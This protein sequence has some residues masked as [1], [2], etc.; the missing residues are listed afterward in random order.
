ML[1]SFSVHFLAIEDLYRFS[2]K[3]VCA[4]RV[5]CKQRNK[6][7]DFLIVVDNNKEN[8]LNSPQ[9]KTKWNSRGI[10]PSWSGQPLIDE[11]RRAYFVFFNKLLQFHLMHSILAEI[12]TSNAPFKCVKCKMRIRFCLW[13]YSSHITHAQPHTCNISCIQYRNFKN[14]W[15]WFEEEF[16][17]CRCSCFCSKR[18]PH[19]FPQTYNNYT[20]RAAQQHSCK[21]HH[22]LSDNNVWV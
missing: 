5:S 12:V 8:I 20:Y 6:I 22:F 10:R 19:V 13:S 11:K 9:N 7:N 2:I 3:L 14:S 21:F 18:V 17:R 4:A 1:I 15:N 16:G